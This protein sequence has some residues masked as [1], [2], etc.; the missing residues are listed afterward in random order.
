[1]KLVTKNFLSFFNIGRGRSVK[2]FFWKKICM[3]VK[4]FNILISAIEAFLH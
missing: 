4:I 3:W 2:M 1:M